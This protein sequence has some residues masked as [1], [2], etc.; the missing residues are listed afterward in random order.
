MRLEWENCKIKIHLQSNGSFK[1]LGNYYQRNNNDKTSMKLLSIYAT[2]ST[3]FLKLLCF[4]V[5]CFTK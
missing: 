4:I 5:T 2:E 3:V 1:I